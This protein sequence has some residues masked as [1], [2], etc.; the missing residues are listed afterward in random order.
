MDLE[1]VTD[2]EAQPSRQVTCQNR[3]ALRSGAEGPP[4]RDQQGAEPRTRHQAEHGGVGDA[5][6]RTKLDITAEVRLHARHRG[7][8][9]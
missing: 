6:S 1:H 9:A 5:I 8:C 2:G 3:F 4:L 7:E